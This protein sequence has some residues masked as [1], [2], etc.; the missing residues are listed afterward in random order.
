MLARDSFFV[1]R[2]WDGSRHYRL[3]VRTTS[4]QC[5]GNT[6][7]LTW[8]KAVKLLNHLPSL[9]VGA[10]SLLCWLTRGQFQLLLLLLRRLLFLL[11]SHTL[12][13]RGCRH[14]NTQLSQL[15]PPVRKSGSISS[16]T[17]AGKPSNC[18]TTVFK[19]SLCFAPSE[20]LL[21]ISG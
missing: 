9:S 8:P 3:V 17:L 10:T 6:T 5:R 13:A 7:E 21:A 15:S 16:L 14:S 2:S 4:T 18:S 11:R 20:H 1:P 12:L 19:I